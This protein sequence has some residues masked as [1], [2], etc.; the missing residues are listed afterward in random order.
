MVWRFV[1]RSDRVRSTDPVRVEVTLAAGG[2]R[3]TFVVDDG[4]RVVDT[5]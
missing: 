5:A 2:D 4:C 1:D 3:A